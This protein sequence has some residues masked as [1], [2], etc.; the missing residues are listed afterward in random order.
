M[1][2]V[3]L[4]WPAPAVSDVHPQMPQLS[5][6]RCVDMLGAQVADQVLSCCIH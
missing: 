6:D 2:E 1:Q 4:E 3:K 5:F